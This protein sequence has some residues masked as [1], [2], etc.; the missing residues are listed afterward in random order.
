[1]MKILRVLPA[2]LF[3]SSLLLVNPAQAK[4]Q[5]FDIEDD[6][7]GNKVQFTSD[8]PIELIHGTTN[9]VNG[10]VSYDDTL[11][12]DP[13]H[14]FN[15]DF[16]VDLASIDT[17]IALRNEHMRDNFLET[18]KYPKAI[19][20]VSKIQST[21]KP[22]LKLGQKVVLKAT[23]SFTVHGKTVTKTIP[24]TVTNRGDKIR[25]QATFPVALEAHA[26]K[27]PEIVFQK[28]ADTVF[29]TIDVM[30]KSK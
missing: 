24:V 27:R 3:L 7:A 1:M 5:Q 25:I 28:L 17:G 10:T 14:P 13:K 29:V 18:G 2:F 20:K 16:S 22:P 8:A 21:T 26:I 9:K 11:T 12:F 30:G 19:F 4:Q 23:G 15:I 6:D